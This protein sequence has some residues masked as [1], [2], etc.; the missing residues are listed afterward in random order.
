MAQLWAA[1]L[2]GTRGFQKL[3]A[4]KTLLPEMLEDPHVERLFLE[5]AKL[6]ARIHHANVVE[7]LELGE[8]EGTLYLAMEW[9]H[10]EPL[11]VIF[12][13]AAP[14]GG[15]PLNIAV[16][17]IGQICRGLHA[18]HELCDESGRPLGLVHRDVTPQNLLV[19]YSGKAKLADFGV[20]KT[21]HGVPDRTQVG[22]I[23]GKLAYMAPEQ[24]ANGP[25]DRRADVFGI[26]IVLYL[27]TTGR[28]PFKRDNPAAT[29]QSICAPEPPVRPAKLVNGYPEALEAAVMKA[30]AKSPE[31]RWATAAEL[32]TALTAGVPDALESSF[33]DGVAEWMNQLFG[34]RAADRVAQL[35]LAQQLAD[36]G[37]LPGS[38]AGKGSGGSF[39][40]V[41]ADY[42]EPSS[43]RHRAPEALSNEAEVPPFREQNRLR[44][45]VVAGATGV[46]CVVGLVALL[47]AVA[48]RQT[49]DAAADEVHAGASR[50]EPA[51]QRQT[52]LP[53]PQSHDTW[54]EQARPV[55]DS[56]AA[57][58]STVAAPPVPTVKSHARAA[59][60]VSPPASLTTAE[61]PA[62]PVVSPPSVSSVGPPRL[63][64]V[65]AWNADTFGGRR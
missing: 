3:V 4:I 64:V 65:D 21:I 25:L 60:K 38:E 23:K 34:P 13:Q 52:A 2:R 59:Q 10:G 22:E 1:R 28:H 19:T 61:R 51:A 8:H 27:L 12:Q 62:T 53:L 46:G 63:H 35:Q 30:L 45:G 47:S 57:P 14:S 31:E 40:A 43:A 9:V 20:A 7:T 49:R 44:R 36:R 39:R 29:L 26:G 33:D 41:S 6:A 50:A 32:L 16:N 54:A 18:A 11:S 15:V 48:H 24:V 56:P 17:L 55:P 37:G 58:S 42:L 5:E